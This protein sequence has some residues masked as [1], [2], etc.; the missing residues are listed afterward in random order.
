MK[1]SIII[2]TCILLLLVTGIGVVAVQVIDKKNIDFFGAS[3][4]MK[5]DKTVVAVVNNDKIYQYQIDIQ[6]ASQKL[7]QTNLVEAGGDPS[8]ISLQTEDEILD[9]L[10]RNLVTL[11]EAKAQKLTAKY[12]DAKKYQEAQFAQIKAANDE[13]TRF[14]EQYRKEMGWD[15]KEHLKQASL[16]WQNV[17]TRT[18]LYNKFFEDNPDA[19][20]EDY[21]K[22]IDSLV[23]KADIEYK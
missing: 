16:E 11:Q 2:I 4:K 5:E 8:L 7:S 10:I 3:K 13:Q 15:E 1:K 23:Q 20:P 6:S 18:N 14:F 9:S 17:M 12:S 19:T 21:E 22:Y